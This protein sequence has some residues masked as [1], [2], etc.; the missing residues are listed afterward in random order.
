[1]S[2][3]IEHAEPARVQKKLPTKRPPACRRSRLVR[4]L[5]SKKAHSSPGSSSVVGTTRGHS[6]AKVSTA[7]R[8]A[9]LGHA[10]CCRGRRGQQT[11]LVDD[12]RSLG[13]VEAGAAAAR[14]RSLI[15]IE[16]AIRLADLGPAATGY[17]LKRASRLEPVRP[18]PRLLDR[19]ANDD[20]LPRPGTRRSHRGG[21]RYRPVG[22]P[23]SPSR[24]W[25]RWH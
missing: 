16:A 21:R 6:H 14:P 1:M 12:P 2:Y 9:I 10:D 19:A 17:V 7:I 23:P 25:R 8:A 11:V 3:L 24:N 18:A 20:R 15:R 5:Y 13:S 4:R 22:T